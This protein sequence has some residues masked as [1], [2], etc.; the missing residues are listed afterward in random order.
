MGFI[1]SILGDSGATLLTAL[2]ALGA[3][4]VL[5]VLA[6]WL[7]KFVFTAT[8]K[9]A[10]AGRG[11]RLGVVETLQLDGRRQLLLVRRD[12]VEHLVL[13]GGTQDLLLEADIPV[14]DLPTPTRR[15]VPVV[16]SRRTRP[17]PAPQAAA[18]AVAS[19]P[20]APA[21][22]APVAAPP[23]SAIE[24]LRDFGRG[25]QP[26]PVSLRHTGLLK[27]GSNGDNHPAHNPDNSAA[28]PLDSAKENTGAKSRENA[29][30]VGGTTKGDR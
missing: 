5:I 21:P 18:P 28:H 14:D 24:R 19:P 22:V 4:L 25:T 15:P 8:G 9:P 17:A 12:N 2:F 13:T 7:L 26:K 11:P 29:E 30:S 6:V 27:P 23:P 10:R 20:A 1:T 3:V 16:P